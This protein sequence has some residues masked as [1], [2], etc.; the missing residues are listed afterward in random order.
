MKTELLLKDPVFQ[1]N[2]L[3]WM[4]KEQP[5]ENYCV[6][7]F[8]HNLGF[9]IL[10]IE[11]P[12]AFPE[13]TSKAMINSG[14]D[15]GIAPEPDLLL[16]RDIDNKALYFEIK[17]NSFSKS[18]SDSKQARAHL[19]ASGPSFGEVFPPLKSCL[20]C[21]VVPGEKRDK[22]SECLYALHEELKGK[23]LLPGES[24]SHGL[25]VNGTEII[26]SWDDIFKAHVE[27][28]HESV[29]ILSGL[30]EDTD[31]SPLILVYS[32][33]DCNNIEMQDFYRRV[34]IDQVRASLLCDLQSH[35]L[36]II[37]DTTP[38]NILLKTTDGI[39]QYLGRKRQK[40][41]RKLV[42]ESIFKRIH[43]TWSEKQTGVKLSG[44]SLSIIWNN[45]REK[46]AFINWLEDRRIK[47]ITE[48]PVE[49]EDAVAISLFDNPI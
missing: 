11:H 4:A 10:Y 42:R 41:L 35:N 26:Y 32:D 25:S 33:E 24:S 14:L 47:F 12:F 28:D 19:M 9:N 21:Y 16:K 49:K 48:K 17:A 31:P 46:E 1:L 43:E 2:L 5:K 27:T 8:F 29:S 38:D 44:N 39:F 22:M 18:S 6:Y 45:I 40:G 13:E 15:I 7:P 3:L 20:L 36:S 23:G 37:Y 30:I 34:L